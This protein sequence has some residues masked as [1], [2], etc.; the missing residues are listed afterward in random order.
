M[1]SLNYMLIEAHKDMIASRV[2]Y[3]DFSAK[4]FEKC[5]TKYLAICAIIECVRKPYRMVD[6]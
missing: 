2:I 5:R 1:N 4:A 6:E 3:N